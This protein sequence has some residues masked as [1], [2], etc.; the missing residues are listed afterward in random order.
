MTGG[1]GN[2][3]YFVDSSQDVVVELAGGG[4]DTIRA[5]ASYVVP[6]NIE[7]L[8]LTG[9][10][11]ID[12]DARSLTTA[13]T[14]YGNGAPN[15]I[16]GGAGNDTYFVDSSQDVVVELAGGGSDTLRASASYVVPANIETLYLTGTNAIDGDAR[17]L[18]TAI[19]I[20]GNGAANQLWG[21]AGNDT[22]DGG[23]G[24]D[25]MTGGTGDD[26]YIVDSSQ[27]IVVELA[28]GGNDTLKTSVSYVVPASI[29]T[30]YLTGSA[31]IDGDARSLTTAI[32]VY[33]NGANNQIWGGS[34]NDYINGGAG[35]DT[36]TGGAGDDTYIVNSSQDV[37]VE[38][39]GGG[40]D[41]IQSSASYVVP[42]NIETLYL[43]GSAAIDGDARGLTTNVG[44]FGN[45]ANNQLWGGS[46]NDYI[47]GGA[48]DDTMTG[49]AGDDTYIVISSQ[50]VVVELTVGGNDNIQSS[51]SYVVPAN[52]ETLYL[53]GSAA[54]DGDARG[55]TTNVGLNGNSASNQL[56]GGSGNDTLNGGAG[57]DIMTGGAGNDYYVVDNVQDVVVELAGGGSDMVSTS[58]SFAAPDEVE[59][60]SMSGSANLWSRGNA[61]GGSVY[62]NSGNNILESGTGNNWLTGGRGTDTFV[63]NAGGHASVADFRAY[64]EADRVDLSAFHDQIASLAVTTLPAGT[65][66][67]MGSG[68]TLFLL[69]MF[70]VTVSGDYVY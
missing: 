58:V 31:A 41:N 42:A 34:G 45:S 50:D 4:S 49:G 65:Q 66:L 17:G 62:G 54:I 23:A 22:L 16:W 67:T 57:A 13:I 10:N 12:G 40:N 47:N 11:A 21:G 70:S 35:D 68:E 44:L 7:T 69:G 30:L 18:A 64:G 39:T 38:L 25:T 63:L 48:G 1:A 36:M 56:W 61:T 9:T 15:Q 6:A 46:G 29:E 2:D 20:Y 32:T 24:D 53:T 51:A 43:T 28:G 5:S 3:T 55:L 8:Y 27:D 14:V 60:L 33:G 37:V 19:T 59:T 26:T 52:I